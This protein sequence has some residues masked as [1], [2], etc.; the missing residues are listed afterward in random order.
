MPYVQI[1]DERVFYA[2]HAATLGEA[3]SVLL[4]HGA[5]GSHL[6]WGYEVRSLP[7]ANVYAVDLPGHGRSGGSGRCSVAAYVESILG[8]MEVLELERA[9]VVGHSMGS[10]IALTLG[11]DHPERAQGLVLIGSGARLRVLPAILQGLLSDF[12][13]TVKTIVSYCYGGGAT[14]QMKR[15]GLRQMLAV[16]ARVLHDDFVACDS[17]DVM[18]RLE[19]LRAPTLIITGAEDVM[20]PPKYAQYLVEYVEG[21]QLTLIEGAGHMVMLERDKLVAQAIMRFLDV[22]Q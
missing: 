9:V 14:E 17:F 20:T 1:S 15:L 10:A 22:L 4:V 7:E 8:F 16:G 3:P 11:I 18:G 5:G 12:D 19:S 21:S 6:H 13:A 2:Y